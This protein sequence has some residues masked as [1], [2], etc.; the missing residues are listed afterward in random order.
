[1]ELTGNLYTYIYI[2]LSSSLEIYKKQSIN[3]SHQMD[4]QSPN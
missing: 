4:T 3:K 1:M 2:Y